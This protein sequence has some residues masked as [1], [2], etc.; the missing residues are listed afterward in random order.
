MSNERDWLA[1]LKPGDK[2]LIESGYGNRR[3]IA[4]VAKITPSGLI[5]IVDGHSR[6]RQKDGWQVGDGASFDKCLLREATPERLATIRLEVRRSRIAKFAW[7]T[8]P[9][10]LVDAVC[11]LVDAAK[12]VSPRTGGTQP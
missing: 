2:V 10:E 4:T 5:S 1:A 8:A 9:A 7:H 6:Y 3:H 12:V 11:A